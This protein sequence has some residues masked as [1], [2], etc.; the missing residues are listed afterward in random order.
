[1]D[2]S[3]INCQVVFE[4]DEIVEMLESLMEEFV[5]V[6]HYYCE[7]LIEAQI[8]FME[9]VEVDYDLGAYS[10]FFKQK[11]CKED[12]DDPEFV[13]FL[14]NNFATNIFINGTAVEIELEN[15][16]VACFV[17]SRGELI[18]RVDEESF[19]IASLYSL[20][21]MPKDVP[22]LLQAIISTLAGIHDEV[23]A[24]EIENDT[25]A[26][27]SGVCLMSISKINELPLNDYMLYLSHDEMLLLGLALNLAIENANE[28]TQTVIRAVME[29]IKAYFPEI[30]HIS[31]ESFEP[32]SHMGQLLD[33]KKPDK[34]TDKEPD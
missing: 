18:L 31:P 13:A 24:S 5:L 4:I 11:Y 22:V 16:R 9:D 23:I 34:Q 10:K 19:V 8:L 7:Q 29:Q 30:E 26:M 1:M 25:F 27:V 32:P 6:E 2:Y 20:K 21:I 14:R 33:F 12:Y 3:L 28:K 15:S 17:G